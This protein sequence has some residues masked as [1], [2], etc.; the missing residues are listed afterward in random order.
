MRKPV[1]KQLKR[2]IY[3]MRL[4]NEAI[5]DPR[6]GGSLALIMKIKGESKVPTNEVLRDFRDE[7]EDDYID[8]AVNRIKGKLGF[9]LPDG[10]K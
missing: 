1:P 3:Y 5:E 6:K 2:L 8:K 7:I 10:L 4:L 9:K